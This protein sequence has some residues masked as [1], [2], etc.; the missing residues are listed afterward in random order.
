MLPAM[1]RLGHDVVALPTVILSSHAGFPHVAGAAVSVDVLEAMAG[2]MEANGWLSGVQ[3]VVTGYLPTAAHV[4]FAAALVDRVRR[5]APGVHFVCDPV[6]GD[7]PKGIYV[8]EETAAAIRSELIPRASLATPNRF[9]LGWLTGHPVTCVTSA[10]AAARA[11][12]CEAV[13]ATSIPHTDGSLATV[14][15]DGSAARFTSVDR[16]ASVPSGTGDYLTG[17]FLAEI[18]AGRSGTDALAMA[19]AYLEVALSAGGPRDDLGLTEVY[20][21]RPAPLPVQQLAANRCKP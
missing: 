1:E 6:L 16:R 8:S 17:L 18:A 21:A 7:D 10:V 2:A 3:F 11:L 15:V 12:G 14:L 9:E 5:R 19:G 4:E 13:L 20:G